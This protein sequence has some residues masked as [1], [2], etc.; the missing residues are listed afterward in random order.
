[1]Q[2]LSPAVISQ[3]QFS[4]AWQSPPICF[5]IAL[6]LTA[7]CFPTERPAFFAGAKRRNSWQSLTRVNKPN[8]MTD[9]ASTLPTHEQTFLRTIKKTA[10]VLLL[11]LILDR[12]ITAREVSRI[13]Q[14]NY[15]TARNYLKDLS[16][17]DLVNLTNR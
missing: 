3:V 7:E 6:V 17:A 14:I 12:S 4:L 16:S 8:L 10:V 11:L 15:E 13:L 1:M 2:Y 5:V 9:S